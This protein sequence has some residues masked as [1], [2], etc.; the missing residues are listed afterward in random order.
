MPETISIVLP[1]KNEAEGLRKT[2]PLIRKLHPDAEIIVVNDGSVDDTKHVVSTVEGVICVNHPKSIGNGG[3]IKSGARR[4]TGDIIVFMDADGQHRPE[5]ICRLLTLFDSGYDLVIGARTKKTQASTIRAI[6]N[7]LYNKLASWMTGFEILD[8]TSGFRAVRRKLFLSILYLLPNKFSY[9][10]TSTMAFFKSGYFVGFIPVEA[11]QR[12]GKS[13]IS[14]FQDGV[15]FL[16]IILKI[17]ALYSPM[18]LFLPISLALFYI[19]TLYYIYTYFS[20]TRFTNMGLLLYSSS[21]MT[22]LMGIVSE[23]ISML[24]Y[25]GTHDNKHLDV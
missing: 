19:A 16:I 10:T 2:L 24:H 3:A 17:G 20:S 4:A 1:A 23:Q 9:P 11:Q 25:K 14:L 6:A 5:D 18:R 22:F 8:L 12:I 21:L 7:S 13:H 15:R